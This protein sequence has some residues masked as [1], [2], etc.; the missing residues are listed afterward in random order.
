MVKAKK[1]RISEGTH[2]EVE[3]KVTEFPLEIFIQQFSAQTYQLIDWHWHSGVQFCYVTKGEVCFQTVKAEHVLHEGDGMFIGSGQ[4]HTAWPK[5]ENSAYISLNLALSFLGLPGSAI[6]EQFVEPVI[7]KSGAE[8]IYFKK[9]NKE[10]AQVLQRLAVCAERAAHE[11][12]RYTL[13][14]YAELVK[15]WEAL[16]QYALQENFPSERKQEN[17][18]LQQIL[19]F[20]QDHSTEKITL[21]QIAE[22][23]HL[24][25]SE[26]SRFFHKATGQSLFEYINALRL[27][28]ST[29]LLLKTDLPIAQIAYE[30]GFGS[31]SYFCQ[32]FHSAKGCSP[33]QF[34]KRAKKF[35]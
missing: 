7:Q 15:L 26:C 1:L 11:E 28:K 25:R 22:N 5:I 31:Q 16:Y 24:S 32:K 34:R 33:E 23:I 9:E 13:G 4:A 21:Q 6:F 17:S 18:R 35:G 3:P 19:N 2:A 10:Q 12:S 27:N 8:C 20:L 14:L 30:V 29:E